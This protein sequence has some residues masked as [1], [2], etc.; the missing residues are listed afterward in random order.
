MVIEQGEIW[1]ADL[2][3]PVGSEP[4]YQRPVLVVQS[5]QFNRSRIGTVLSVPLTGTLKWA[6]AHGT[7]LLKPHDTGLD[8]ASVAQASSTIALDR[9][10]FSQ[11]AGQVS[12]RKLEQVFAAIDAVLGR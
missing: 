7:V 5:D 6:E 4:G 9:T 2:G 10:R 1:W 3:D 12:R 11:R 8:R